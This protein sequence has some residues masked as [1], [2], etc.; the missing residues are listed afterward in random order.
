M[1]ER[2]EVPSG[3][4]CGSSILLTSAP[5]LCLLSWVVSLNECV[6]L[7]VAQ[8]EGGGD[9]GH[10]RRQVDRIRAKDSRSLETREKA[11]LH[12]SSG[13]SWETGSQPVWV[14]L[15]PVESTGASVGSGLEVVQV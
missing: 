3:Q 12:L 4:F 2:D 7:L 5:V 8:V 6:G 9:R 10:G 14:I 13:W 1:W 15:I 11:H